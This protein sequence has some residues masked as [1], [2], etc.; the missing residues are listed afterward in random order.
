MESYNNKMEGYIQEILSENPFY[1]SNWLAIKEE[2]EESFLHLIENWHKFT[3]R[4]KDSDYIVQKSIKFSFSIFKAIYKRRPQLCVSVFPVVIFIIADSFYNFCEIAYTGK[5]RLLPKELNPQQEEK[6]YDLFHNIMTQDHK[7]YYLLSL[8]NSKGITYNESSFDIGN[9]I[10]KLVL[11]EY[12]KLEDT[13]NSDEDGL[14]DPYDWSEDD[15][16]EAQILLNV[17]NKLK[18][19]S[20][21]TLKQRKRN[22]NLEAPL[23]QQKLW[24]EKI[25]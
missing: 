25:I 14:S 17:F 6:I 22:V 15:Y 19:D 7:T 23:N 10:S 24:L 18:K 2:F 20:R 9:E 8:L 11:K 3:P 4:S 13:R 1:I 16:F 5:K 21:T 12:K